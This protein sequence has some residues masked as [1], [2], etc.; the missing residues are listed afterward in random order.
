MKTKLKLNNLK[1]E[2]FTN[3]EMKSIIG[4]S[5]IWGSCNGRVSCSGPCGHNGFSG[6]CGVVERLVFGSGM[7]IRCEC[8]GLAYGDDASYHEPYL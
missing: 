6:D 4:G 8:V 5:D 2:L 7:E 1:D 3:E